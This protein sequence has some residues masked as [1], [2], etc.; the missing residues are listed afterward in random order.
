MSTS[1][2]APVVSE[3]CLI[4]ASISCRLDGSAMSESGTTA[5]GVIGRE[6]EY[7]SSCNYFIFRGHHKIFLHLPPGDKSLN[8]RCESNCLSVC[9]LFTVSLNEI[10]QNDSLPIEEGHGLFYFSSRKIHQGDAIPR[11][12]G[13]SRG[14]QVLQ[15]VRYPYR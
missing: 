13:F 8:Y 3:R 12:R 9:Y 14:L 11:G 7:A 5:G 15:L 6:G 2:V 1:A 4:L 10:L